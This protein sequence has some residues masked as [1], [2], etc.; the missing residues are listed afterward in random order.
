MEEPKKVPHQK[1]RLRGNAIKRMPDIDRFWTLV[2]R[3]GGADACWPWLSGTNPYGYG[4]FRVH[5]T[6]YL[7]TRWL[8]SHLLGRALRWDGEVREFVCHRCDNPPCV[9][10]AH[11]YIGD[12]FTNMQDCVARGRNPRAQKTHCP[13][14]HEYTPDNTYVN[15][16]RRTCRECALRR[17]RA[18][19]ARRAA[20]RWETSS[21]PETQGSSDAT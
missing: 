13:Q 4:R 15:G 21:S 3:S 17:S 10:P 18:Q 8:M 11:L 6:T 7:A 1:T 9:N 2:D 14:G 20:A 16:G 12:G 19:K 5:P